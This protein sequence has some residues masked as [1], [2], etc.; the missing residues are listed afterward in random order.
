[1]QKFIF[2]IIVA[3]AFSALGFSF[4]R[5]CPLGARLGV[6]NAQA[7][8]VNSGDPRAT[9]S[10]ISLLATVRAQIELYKLQHNDNY[11]EFGKY[12]WKQ[13]TYKTNNKGQI[14]EQGKELSSAVFGPYFQSP[15]RNFL[16]KSSE[17]LVV[18]AIG[19]NFKATGSYGF[20]LEESTGKLFALAADGKLFDESSA[21]ADAH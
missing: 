5:F 12:G 3:V 17:V 8:S 4:A 10:L 9:S 6:S 19:E 2:F 16:T 7:S 14:T 1:M 15:P 18:S 21:A 13:L 11:P 20:V